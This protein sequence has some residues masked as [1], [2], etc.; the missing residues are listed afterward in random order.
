M[1]GSDPGGE[2]SFG[3]Q[4][5]AAGDLD[6]VVR[7]AAQLVSEVGDQIVEPAVLAHE[8]HGRLAR[9]GLC[10][11]ENRRLDPEHPFAPAGG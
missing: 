1:R 5:I 8:A 4:G 2:A 11:G 7:A 6:E 3:A 10:G 9:D